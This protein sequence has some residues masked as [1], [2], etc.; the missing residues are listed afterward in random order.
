MAA[1]HVSEHGLQIMWASVVVT[2]GLK[3]QTQ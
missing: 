3:A 2:R 1:S